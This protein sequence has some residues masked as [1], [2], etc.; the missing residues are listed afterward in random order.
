MRGV[1]GD[2]PKAL[3]PVAG[4]P[5]VFHLL[6]RLEESGFDEVLLCVGHGSSRIREAVAAR[7]GHIRA[8]YAEDGATLLG[9]LGAIVRAKAMLDASFLV[10]YGDSFLT[11]DYAGPLRMLEASTD[12]L[13]CM[14]V[15]ENHDSLEPSNVAVARD[16]VIRYDKRPASD[17]LASGAKPRLDHI[18]YGAI[19][20]RREAIEGLP[21]DRPLGLDGLQSSLA[22]AGKLLALRVEDR[23]YEIGSPRGLADLEHWFATRGHPGKLQP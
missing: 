13:G 9:T 5:F 3:I 6:T 21:V 16:R 18:D 14:A 10:T 17:D 11:F 1:A 20:L 8:S 22:S 12:A 2:T 23:F 15:F 4:L 19:A 7:A